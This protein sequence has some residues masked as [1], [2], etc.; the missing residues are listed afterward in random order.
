MKFKLMYGMLTHNLITLKLTA[1]APGPHPK[2]TLG[3][4]LAPMT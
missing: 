4:T 1:F 3:Q 2:L